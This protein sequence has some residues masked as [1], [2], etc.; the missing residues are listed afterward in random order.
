M[1][2]GGQAAYSGRVSWLSAQI[3][4]ALFEVDLEGAPG[5]QRTLWRA[6]RIGYAVLRDLLAG[7]LS[8][9]AMSLA[10]TSLLS[11]VPL[12]AV[13]F[14]VLKGFGVHNQIEPLLLRLL[15][16]IGP[17]AGQIAQHVIGFVDNVQ[18]GV[19]GSLGLAVLIYTVISLIQKIETTF[20]QIWRTTQMRSLGE[21]FS[22]YMSV[23]LV[24][25]VLLFSA[26][27][28]LGSVLEAP[29]VRS[30]LDLPGVGFLLRA[31]AELL[32]LALIYAGFAFL[33]AFVPTVDVR[34]RPALVGA[35]VGGALWRGVGLLFGRFVAAAAG[36][37]AIYSGFA[38]VIVGMV[39]LNVGWI[40][41]LLGA[42]VAF[43]VQNPE[44]VRRIDG[45]PRLSNLQRE[46][47]ALLVLYVIAR[48]FELE[49]P[50][51][52]EAALVRWLGIP[53]DV[54]APVLGGLEEQ[55][56]LARTAARPSGWIPAAGLE[57]ISL[58]E[59]L[60]AIRTADQDLTIDAGLP[61]PPPVA[62]VF[63]TLEQAS[64]AALGGQTLAELGRAPALSA[65]PGGRGREERPA[66]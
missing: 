65:E 24:G 36:Y 3:E 28:A 66:H 6:L 2:P 18:V 37:D 62:R 57:R 47:L 8:L 5:P 50:H 15:A 34:I 1:P 12:L 64:A 19:L 61:D 60:A 14:S 10:Y 59:A 11:L 39:W 23:V 41:V 38:I 46:R 32:P 9:R 33:Y 7:Q 35:A 20:N 53:G 17:A 55:G 58:R 52:T 4:H 27:T 31:A 48:D 44:C 49:R 43:Y 54:V 45:P 26:V 40:T 63:E 22:D 13:S 16:P 56:L 30:V 21:R 51:W 29:L 42:S 25:P